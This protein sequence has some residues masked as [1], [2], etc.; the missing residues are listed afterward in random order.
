MASGQAVVASDLAAVREVLDDGVT[1]LLCPPGDIAA[2]RLA[3]QRLIDE[4]A[5]ARALGEEA[6]RRVETR[7][8]WARRARLA[9]GDDQAPNDA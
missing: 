9:L 6:R 5:F 8:S 7:H 2:W 3:V 4:P 1:A